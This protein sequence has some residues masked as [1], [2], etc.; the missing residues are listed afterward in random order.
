[1]DLSHQHL[2]TPGWGTARSSQ[3]SYVKKT[4]KM[5][6][7][8]RNPKMAMLRVCR[9]APEVPW[10][11]SQKSIIPCHHFASA[12]TPRDTQTRDLKVS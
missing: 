4:I 7:P 3:S 9:L 6:F 2:Q 1:M 12:P 11:I 5:R 8:A 10:G